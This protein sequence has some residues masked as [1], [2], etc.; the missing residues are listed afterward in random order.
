RHQIE[1]AT[2]GR[3]LRE[4]GDAVDAMTADR[5]LV[6][7]IEDLHWSDHATLDLTLW[8]LGYADQAVQ[9]GEATPPLAEE[10][11]P[12]PKLAGAP[13]FL[14]RLYQFLGDAG[15]TRALAESTMRL[16][17]EQGFAQRLAASTILA[18][19]ARVAAGDAEGLPAMMSGLADFRATGAGDDI[20]Y[21]LALVAEA[22]LAAGQVAAASRDLDEAL[23][24]TGPA[25]PPIG[26]PGA[27]RL[28]GEPRRASGG[29]R[30]GA[31]A[32]SPGALSAA[33]R[34]QARSHELRA[35]PALARLW[36]STRRSDDAR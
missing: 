32:A 28:G 23:A 9:R 14:A 31:E 19:W 24:P 3:M 33:R 22:R 17:R 1:G 15:G 35:A 29:D 2:R 8:A 21:W 18:G 27:P 36:R 26:E 11:G 12:P 13:I 20:P 25:G 4:M 10:T 6:L 16:A 30:D 7:V 5:A 34:H